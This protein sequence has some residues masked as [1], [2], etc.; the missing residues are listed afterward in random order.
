MR[1]D[2]TAEKAVKRVP[3]FVRK[4]VRARIEEEARQAGANLVTASHVASAQAKFLAGLENEV[5]GWRLESCFGP[6]GC[7]KRAV[8]SDR[9][10]PELEKI[11]ARG[12]LKEFLRD[13][14]DGPLKPHHEFQAVIA[15]CPNCCSRPQIADLGLIGARKPLVGVTPCSGCGAC[16]E[17]CREEALS[18]A[19]GSDH[20]VLDE[21]RC[22][23]CGQ[24][25]DVCPTGTLEEG[26]AGFRIQVGGKLG[27]RP[28]LG[29]ELPGIYT[30]E[31]AA[32]LLS[33]FLE[34]FKNNNRS[35]ERWGEIIKRL[36]LESVVDLIKTRP[37][38]PRG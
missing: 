10:I 2:E 36:G 30:E 9:L 6:S 12:G 3:F 32:A 8:A 4:K 15:D 20:P 27:R 13:K 16:I 29:M 18:L 17:T 14:V 22:L 37:G 33:S 25:I 24:C 21:E 1:W 19:Q 5:R 34:H 23:A 31:E 28:Q 26:L 7:E 35:G 38:H 11:L